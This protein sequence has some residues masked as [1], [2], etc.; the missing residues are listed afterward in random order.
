MTEV[1]VNGG[2]LD[3]Q[4]M[5]DLASNGAALEQAKKSYMLPNSQKEIERMRNQHE[6]IKGSFGGLIKAPIDFEKKDQKILDSATA[7]G[8]FLP[9]IRHI[10][11]LQSDAIIGTWVFD[12]RTLFPPETELVGFDIA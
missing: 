4:Q 12:A 10:A 11:T 6:W 5:T 1:A 2:T 7:D 9:F 3:H 8:N